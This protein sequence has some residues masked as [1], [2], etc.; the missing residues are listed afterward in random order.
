MK[1]NFRYLSYFLGIICSIA[2]LSCLDEDYFLEQF[3]KKYNKQ[4]EKLFGKMD[5]EHDWNIIQQV[6][7]TVQVSEAGEHTLRIYTDHPKNKQ[8]RLVA[9]IPVEGTGTIR[10]DLEKISKD[11][12]ARVK[13]AQGKVTFEGYFAV[14]GGEVLIDEGN[15]VSRL[16]SRAVNVNNSLFFTHNL[17]TI[18]RDGITELNEI[19]QTGL[20]QES[21][22]NLGTIYYPNNPIQT[23]GTERIEFNNYLKPIVNNTSGNSI[24]KE[25]I[26]NRTKTDVKGVE[27]IMQSDDEIELSYIFGVTGLYNTIGYFYWNPDWDSNKNE[28]TNYEDALKIV[29]LEDAQPDATLYRVHGNDSTIKLNNGVD[30]YKYIYEDNSITHLQGN[31]YKLY[32]YGKDYQSQPTTTFPKGTHIAFFL[33]TSYW[34]LDQENSNSPYPNY[35][36]YAY[37]RKNPRTIVDNNRYRRTI[38]YSIPEYNK[39]IK[40]NYNYR[41]NHNDY[42]GKNNGATATIDTSRGEISAVTYTYQG[43]KILGFEDGVDK[44]MNDIM[45]LVDADVKVV[46]EDSNVNDFEEQDKN[47]VDPQAQSWIIACEDMGNIGDYDFNDA[48][49]KV[50]HIAGTNQLKVTPLAAGG[51][52]SIIVKYKGQNISTYTGQGEKDF[53]QLI[54]SNA[55]G[56]NGLWQQINDKSKGSAGAEITITDDALINNPFSLANNDYNNHGFSVYVEKNNGASIT[57]TQP[58][59]KSQ[60]A[61]QMLILPEYWIWP[62]EGRSIHLGYSGFQAWTNSQSENE[63]WYTKPDKTQSNGYLVD[64]NSFSNYP[65]NGEGG[66]NS[67]E[68]TPNIPTSIPLTVDNQQ[69]SNLD[70]IQGGSG[71]Y[72][73]IPKSNFSTNGATLTITTNGGETNPCLFRGD[74]Y[75]SGDYGISKS[76]GVYTLELSADQVNQISADPVKL[77][78]WN[79]SIST[80][81]GINITNKIGVSGFNGEKIN[82]YTIYTIPILDPYKADNVNGIKVTVTLTSAQA[83]N[84]AFFSNKS[85]YTYHDVHSPQQIQAG[86]SYEFTISKDKYQNLSN[87]YTGTQDQNAGIAS[88]SVEVVKTVTLQI[89]GGATS[90]LTLEGTEGN[91]YVTIP[92]GTFGDNGAT[93]E[94]T[95]SDQNSQIQNVTVGGQNGYT[96]VTNNNGYLKIEVLNTMVNSSTATEI[97]IPNTV[98]S[99]VITNKSGGN[100]NNGIAFTV[101]DVQQS[102][103]TWTTGD[104][105]PYLTIPKTALTGNNGATITITSNADLGGQL[106]SG[107]VT[108][109]INSNKTIELTADNISNLSESIYIYV[110]TGYQSITAI[111]ITNNNTTQGGGESG[112]GETTTTD[113]MNYCST[114]KKTATIPKSDLPIG[115]NGISISL[116]ISK[117]TNIIVGQAIQIWDNGIQGYGTS[118]TK[119]ISQ[120][121]INK[122]SGD[123]IVIWLNDADAT[124]T[125]I[126]ITAAN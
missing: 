121:E 58:E 28:S 73:G 118:F 7:A 36:N 44:D 48:V 80:V 59:H 1:N 70:V 32:Y 94:F 109:T 120:T 47:Y 39:L 40:E 18:Q 117:E 17:G 104:G 14:N 106:S 3:E 15:I 6:N 22:I 79:T 85:S 54:N 30:L 2:F 111:S 97:R 52:Y 61:P 114:D 122:I 100:N 50:S 8:S 113:W 67:G 27:Y 42:S 25:F 115:N 78:F 119:T 105:N 10:F 62:Y 51:T 11:V 16:A 38:V 84:V 89:T 81:T 124:I 93:I 110:W 49:F 43:K 98:T 125:N 87:I 116:N 21:T 65:N 77:Y 103:L 41:I 82:G 112:G 57:I 13:D 102:N 24:F 23:T 29:F 75:Q 37:D 88:I 68:V 76:N 31:K 26:D 99:I 35:G 91:Y 12:Y 95:S 126:E 60:Q 86:Q 9:Q 33:Y 46:G 101:D 55:S 72:V 63:D 5:P 74:S 19:S 96:T 71:C 64:Y 20:N 92:A 66:G 90:T 53:H 123:N 34:Y 45:L 56:N 108:V 69:Q 107:S 83:T 4:W